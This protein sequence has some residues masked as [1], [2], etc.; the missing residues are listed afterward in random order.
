[1]YYTP[2]RYRGPEGPRARLRAL[3]NPKDQKDVCGLKSTGANCRPITLSILRRKERS[4]DVTARHGCLALS[5]YRL[6]T[7]II[8][9]NANNL[10]RQATSVLCINCLYGCISCRS[11]KASHDFYIDPITPDVLPSDD[12]LHLARVG[13]TRNHTCCVFV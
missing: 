1:M 10:P 2:W 12:L 5:S 4:R 7:P 11:V 9:L 13:V 8:V 6:P 3:A